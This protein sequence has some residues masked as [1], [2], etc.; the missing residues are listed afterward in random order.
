MQLAVPLTRPL[1][2]HLPLDRHLTTQ[3]GLWIPQYLRGTGGWG[4]GVWGGLSGWVD[5]RVDW[6]VQRCTELWGRGCRSTCV[7]QGMVL[8]GLFAGW[9]AVD[10]D[11]PPTHPRTHHLPAHPYTHLPTHTPA[12]PTH[13]FHSMPLQQSLPRQLGSRAFP[14]PPPPPTPPPPPAHK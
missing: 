2:N 14:P 10:K 13:T 8:E 11:A 9:L 7:D 12:P 4:V 1:Q 5:R 6:W 3:A